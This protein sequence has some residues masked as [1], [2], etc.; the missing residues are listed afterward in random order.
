VQFNGQKK[1]IGRAIF[2]S[3]H[4]DLKAFER[5]Q[6]LAN[7]PLMVSAGSHGVVALFRYGVVVLFGMNHVEEVAFLKNI[8][9]FYKDPFEHY[10]E[11]EAHLCLTEAIQEGNANHE[12]PLDNF[13]VERLQVVASVLAKSVTL[14]HYEAELDKTFEAIEPL[15]R[16]LQQGNIFTRHDDELLSY[17]GDALLI[18]GSMIGHVGI[19]DKPELLWE[20]PQYERLH[21]RMTE[22][23]ELIE[24]HR[25]LERKLELVSKTAETLLGLL[26]NKRA[27]RLE[28]SIVILIVIEVFISL[29]EMWGKHFSA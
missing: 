27:H 12:I 10:E 16:T 24:R 29:Y 15:A 26:Q 18:Q 13:N 11:E 20:G 6:S 21:V 1:L 3:R 23:Y 22:E 8:E 17:I 25:L 28:W 7:N 4:L 2:M 5:A 14:A 9:V 19:S